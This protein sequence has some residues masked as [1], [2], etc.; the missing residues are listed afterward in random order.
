MAANIMRRTNLN[1]E[2]HVC[3]NLPPLVLGS[4]DDLAKI[5]RTRVVDEVVV[6]SVL[7][8][9]SL[10]TVST[11][12]HTRGTIL[13]LMLEVPT[14]SFGTWNIEHLE[15]GQFILSTSAVSLDAFRLTAKRLIDLAGAIVGL[16]ACAVA[17]M[18]Y[19][20]RLRVESGASPIFHQRRV[21]QNGRRFTIYKFRTMVHDAETRLKDLRNNNVM[22]GPMF[23]MPHDPR[24]TATGGVLRRRHL[25]ELPQFWN[26]FK[27]DMSLV[28]TR[29]P[30]ED[31]TKDYQ[32]YHYKRLSMK[33]GLTGL[34]QINGNSE[35]NDFEDVVK[36]DCTYIEKWSLLLDFR[37]MLATIRKIIR[38]DAW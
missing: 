30:T 16:L 14:P 6:A 17:Y 8:P 21:G 35:V 26:V 20:R 5:L 34:W 31:E 32:N 25:D 1:G 13:S 15:H 4:L 37:I 29:P 28:G 9:P 24:V 11:C 36:L 18:I 27:G 2:G 22:N 33:P 7:D 19:G 10:A 3:D 12:C 23:K 38:A